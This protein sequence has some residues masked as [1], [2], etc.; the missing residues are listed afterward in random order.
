MRKETKKKNWLHKVANFA[1]DAQYSYMLIGKK[2]ILHRNKYEN[3]NET[4]MILEDKLN[5]TWHQENMKNSKK[6]IEHNDTDDFFYKR[7]WSCTWISLNLMN[8]FFII[9]YYYY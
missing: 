6:N 8:N 2:I 9:Y 1:R 4:E 5:E 3:A 7:K